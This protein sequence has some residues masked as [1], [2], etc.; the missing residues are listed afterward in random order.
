[1]HAVNLEGWRVERGSMVF[2]SFRLGFDGSHEIMPHLKRGHNFNQA[3]KGMD[4]MG[5][6]RK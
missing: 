3:I 6:W 2:L 4:S 5:K 1:M